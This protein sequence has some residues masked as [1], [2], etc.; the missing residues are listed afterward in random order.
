MPSIGLFGGTFDPIHSGHLHIAR[1]FANEL[2]LSSVIFL[3]AGDPYHKTAPHPRRPPPR[4][5]RNR[6]PPTPAS[7]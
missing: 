3:P 5:G 7:P 1:S 2:R 6:C 4:H